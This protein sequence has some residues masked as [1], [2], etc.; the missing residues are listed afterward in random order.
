MLNT[1]HEQ[2]A[3]LFFENLN[4]RNKSQITLKGKH[5][6]QL[7]ASNCFLSDISL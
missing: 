7:L 1:K 6:L 3:R 4:Q 5:L 2:C